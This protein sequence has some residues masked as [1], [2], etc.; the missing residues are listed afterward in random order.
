MFVYLGTYSLVCTGYVWYD[1]T[2][3]QELYV[4]I[5]NMCTDIGIVTCTI[6]Y[7]N[8]ITFISIK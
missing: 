3:C 7:S 4:G 8:M 5:M 1:K 6:I 2:W